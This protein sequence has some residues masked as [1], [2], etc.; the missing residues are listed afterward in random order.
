MYTNTFAKTIFSL[1]LVLGIYLCFIGGYGSDE[2]TLPMIGTFINFLN[3]NFMTSR[4]TGYPVAEFIIGFFSYHFG[5]T[6]INILIFTFFIIGSA[7]FYNSTQKVYNLNKTIFFLILL[8]SNPIL[9]FDNLEPV[10]Y[11][12]SFFFFSL[13]Y[14]FFVKNKIELAVLFFG[15]CIG[16]RI[17]F[18]PFVLLLIYF[19]NSKFYND[20]YRKLTIILVSIFIG[21]L[22]YLP[23]W[24]HSSLGFD[25]LRAGRPTGGM[26]DYL[27]RF[28]YKIIIS[29]GILQLILIIYLI[30][31]KKF[32]N[33]YKKK[34]NFIIYLIIAN[35]LIFLYIPAELSYLQPLL[36]FYYYL[37][38][39]YFNKKYIILLILI[40]LSSWFFEIKPLK[41]IHKYNDICDPIVATDLE[42]KPNLVKGYLFQYLDNRKK[43]S[44]WIDENSE[45][46]KKILNGGALK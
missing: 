2:D 12:I 24:I 34:D 1:F 22:F 26:I 19:N 39:K 11:S 5:S 31:K 32:E 35:L 37:F 10:D 41:I 33:K 42:F 3:G 28:L 4:F 44:C 6:S 7:I 21:C 9:F 36:I 27:A 18:A 25:W 17:N 38:F 40:N 13:G 30:Y 23:V 14:Y 29:V 16:T 46:G 15:I 20:N 8:L 45:Y 43:I